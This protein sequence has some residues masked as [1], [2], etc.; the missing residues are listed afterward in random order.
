MNC[1]GDRRTIYTGGCDEKLN[2]S[3]KSCA[4]YVGALTL[5]CPT[6]MWINLR[7]R[8]LRGRGPV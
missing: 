2:M 5:P 1:F 3:K 4:N 8:P 7:A 6:E